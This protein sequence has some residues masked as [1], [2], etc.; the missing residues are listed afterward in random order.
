MLVDVWL[1]E[2]AS[3]DVFVEHAISIYVTAA[4]QNFDDYC[5]RVC[6]QREQRLRTYRVIA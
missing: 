5:V 2:T 3:I 4:Y 6:K 1:R